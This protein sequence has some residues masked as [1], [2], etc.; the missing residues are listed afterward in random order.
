MTLWR[1]PLPQSEPTQNIGNYYI[2]RLIFELSSWWQESEAVRFQTK[3]TKT[4]Q[5]PTDWNCALRCQLRYHQSAAGINCR[6]ENLDPC[7]LVAGERSSSVPDEADED[8]TGTNRLELCFALPTHISPIRPWENLLLRE[9]NPRQTAALD[10]YTS[11]PQIFVAIC[12]FE[13]L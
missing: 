8:Q 2:N 9:L 12:N 10:H 7:K 13:V 5:G 1:S 6:Y 11:H 4:R 3:Q